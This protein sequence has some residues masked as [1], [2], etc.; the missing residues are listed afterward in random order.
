MSSIT[1]ITTF[2]VL[3]FLVFSL[4]YKFGLLKDWSTATPKPYSYARTQLCWWTI[5]IVSS[6]I[7]IFISKGNLPTLDSSIVILLGISSGTTAIANVID[8][9]DNSKTT[10]LSR[11]QLS[12]GFL[13]DILSD[14]N[15]ISIHRL[16]ALLFN[17]VIGVWVLYSVYNGLINCNA[18]VNSTCINSIIPVID[19]SKLLLLGVSASAYAGLKANENK[20]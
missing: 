7:S 15:G 14:A 17:L 13:I 19:N 5:I 3:L 4:N 18:N 10:T 9:S 2:C 8:I 20:N 16:Q 12:E 6:F 1:L 11:N